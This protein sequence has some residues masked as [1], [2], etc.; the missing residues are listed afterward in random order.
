MMPFFSWLLMV[1][2]NMWPH[3]PSTTL[4]ARRY[5]LAG[6]LA[7]PGERRMQLDS[8]EPFLAGDRSCSHVGHGLSPWF[9]RFRA[10]ASALFELLVT[11][12]TLH[13]PSRERS[14]SKP[15]PTDLQDST[16][17]TVHSGRQRAG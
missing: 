17:L 2:G 8:L 12:T 7:W 14:L 10:P 1:L 11:A 6:A 15:C 3:L 9:A 16:L 13:V 4:L 5:R